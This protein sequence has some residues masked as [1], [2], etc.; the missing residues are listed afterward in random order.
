MID[1]YYSL[2]MFCNGYVELF[3]TY[4]SLEMCQ[5]AAIKLGDGAACIELSLLQSLVIN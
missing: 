4:P 2:V 1:F 3:Y 5:R